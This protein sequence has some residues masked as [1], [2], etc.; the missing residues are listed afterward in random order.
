MCVCEG[1][2]DLRFYVRFLEAASSYGKILVTAVIY[3]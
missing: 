1:T 2:Y 3:Y